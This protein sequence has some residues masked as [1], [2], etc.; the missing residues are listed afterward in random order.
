MGRV[1]RAKYWTGKSYTKREALQRGRGEGK[2]KEG[3]VGGKEGES[4]R[5]RERCGNW[6]RVSLDF[7]AVC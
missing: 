2:G 5:E 6:L 3:E 7:S 4:K 1:C